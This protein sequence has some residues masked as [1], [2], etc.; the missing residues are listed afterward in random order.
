M[1]FPRYNWG[2]FIHLL[3]V[4]PSGLLAVLQFTPVIRAKYRRF[5]RFAGYASSI[6]A[7]SGIVSAFAI[8]DRSF[9]GDISIVSVTAVTG[10]ASAYAL[11]K[12]VQEAR[13]K[14]FAAHRDWMLRA[15][16]YLGTIATMR[17]FMGLLV[18]TIQIP[19]IRQFT[20]IPCEVVLNI[21]EDNNMAAYAA[22]PLCDPINSGL[23]P[24]G[25]VVVPANIA[26]LDDVEKAA[27]GH[28][29][30]GTAMWIAVVIHAVGVEVYLT[31][32]RQSAA[33]PK[34]KTAKVE[35]KMEADAAISVS[36]DSLKAAQAFTSAVASQPMPTGLSQ[37]T[38]LTR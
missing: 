32:T 30:F 17:P 14:R 33:S 37:M 36:E 3:S 6:L 27:A 35:Q 12:G 23:N 11:Y 2:I 21:F 25:R 20:T 26:S 18:A 16:M 13:A 22:Y 4:L 7:V 31:W 29:V 1:N 34:A 5:H 38:T 8:A 9:G 10:F 15:W 24:T 19:A 28:V